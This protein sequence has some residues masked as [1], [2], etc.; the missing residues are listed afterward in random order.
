MTTEASMRL[1]RR[2]MDGQ[3]Q[4]DVA[5]VGLYQL[6]ILSAPLTRPLAFNLEAEVRRD[7]V[8]MEMKAGDMNMWLRAP[9]VPSTI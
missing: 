8:R 7:T 5:D 6:G 2:Y 4:M 9:K 1:G 3:L